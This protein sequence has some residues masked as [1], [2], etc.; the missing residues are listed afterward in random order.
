MAALYPAAFFF[1]EWT[2]SGGLP[3]LAAEGLA[4]TA[5]GADAL[6]L[7]SLGRG[8][9][10]VL[11]NLDAVI[12]TLAGIVQEDKAHL[13]QHPPLKTFFLGERLL[14]NNAEALFGRSSSS[15]RVRI[16]VTLPTEAAHDYGFVRDLLQRGMNCARI[17]CAH[18]AP[19][20]WE[21]M[22]A[23][24]RRAEQESERTCKVLMDLGG[25][26][27]R[28]DQVALPEPK[29]RLHVGE[30]LHYNRTFEKKSKHPRSQPVEG[31]SS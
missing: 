11:A 6:G 2:Q 17:N 5:G 16:M 21:A 24:V 1:A 12:A 10:R 8:E 30:R 25:P 19:A 13:P 20:E 29:Q 4:P 23:H 22:I 14:N 3:G 15:R 18:D 27:A 28:T 31:L 26:K 7:S 9:S